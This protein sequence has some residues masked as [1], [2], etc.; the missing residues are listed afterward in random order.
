MNNLT[1]AQFFHWYYP[2]ENN[3]WLHVKAEAERLA[4]LGITHVWLPPA[5]KSA[6]GENEAG[7]A[8]YDLY[9]L[10]E[11]D[12]K[13]SVRT[14]Y[15]TRD[16]YLQAIEALHNNGIQVLADIVLNH[17]AGGDEEETVTVH[18]VQADNRNQADS[19]TYTTKAFTHFTFPGRNKKYSSFIWDWQC[20]SGTSIDNKI[21][22]IHNQ[23]SQN[24]WDNV[25]GTENGNFDYLMGNDVNFR[26]PYVAEELKNWGKWYAATTGID[27]F[28]VDALKHMNTAFLTA[29]LQTIR[30]D[31]KKDMLFIGEYWKGEKEQLLEYINQT[32]GII[33]L[34]DVGL[35]YSFQQAAQQ[36]NRFD[37]RSIFNNTLVANNPA[38]TITFTDNHDTQPLQTTA[39][40]ID[41]WFR[42]IAYAL[43]LLRE[44][45]IP[46]IFYPDLYGAGYTMNDQHIHLDKVPGMELMLRVRKDIAYGKQ[47]DYFDDP[48]IIGW[49]RAGN[50]DKAGS[51]CAVLI[52]N[53]SGGEKRMMLGQQH[54][55]KTFKDL[56]GNRNETV[57]L[58]EQGEGTFFVNGGKVSVWVSEEYMS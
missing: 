47:Q 10:G 22:I 11:F 19:Q 5:Y 8:A 28:R 6:G 26:N 31:Q 36:G 12:Q 35:H 52:S 45:G 51:G 16:E 9:D 29:W 44:Q 21:A 58:N 25:P 4:A 55:L 46:C 56:L 50:D 54:R 3:L 30:E 20:F 15:G 27:G 24:Q 49:T 43:I 14:K 57:E 42:P 53:D 39:S 17:K 38:L 13:G 2:R 40:F 48:H 18:N 32:N 41:N 23:Y 7:Y 1:I 37:M 33:Q 34:F